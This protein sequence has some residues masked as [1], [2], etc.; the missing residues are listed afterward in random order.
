[1]LNKFLCVSKN[2]I[3]YINYVAAKHSIK[4]KWKTVTLK[5]LT[6]HPVISRRRFQIQKFLASLSNAHGVS[7]L[8]R[9]PCYLQSS[10]PTKRMH[11]GLFIILSLDLMRFRFQS[12]PFARRNSSSSCIAINFREEKI[13]RNIEYN[14]DIKNCK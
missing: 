13:L 14:I 6:P 10:C 12:K 7:T 9:N 3:N 2:L 4:L 8:M 1:M 5:H 11:R